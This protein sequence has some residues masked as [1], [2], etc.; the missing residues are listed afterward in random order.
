MYRSVIKVVVCA[1]CDQLQAKL[2]RVQVLAANGEAGSDSRDSF[3]DSDTDSDDDAGA[4]KSQQV[5]PK[6]HMSLLD[7]HSKLKLE[8]LGNRPIYGMI[9][10]C[11]G[12]QF[13]IVI[14]GT[15]WWISVRIRA[16]PHGVQLSAQPSTSV[17]RRP[18]PVC[19][20]CRLQ[21]TPSLCQPRSSRRA[22]L[23]SQQLRSAGFFCGWPCDMELVTRQSERPSHQQRLFQTFTEDVFI[24]SLLV[25]IAH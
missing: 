21:T 14:Y 15:Y 6:S 2:S 7:Q 24:F 12:L 13:T 20:Q 16:R 9:A 10:F 17:H 1:L 19:I 23:S 25:Y 8:A 11:R 4:E 18:L 3:H 22:S 5:G